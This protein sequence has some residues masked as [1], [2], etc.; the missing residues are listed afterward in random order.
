MIR[1]IM[2]HTIVIDAIVITAIGRAPKLTR[3]MTTT[4]FDL[5]GV[6]VI[7]IR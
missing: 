7:V 4:S 1:P 3:G 2:A 6:V 5:G